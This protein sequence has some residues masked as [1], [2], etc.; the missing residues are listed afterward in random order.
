MANALFSYDDIAAGQR[1]ADVAGEKLPA[2][3][4]VLHAIKTGPKRRLPEAA[5]EAFSGGLLSN[6]YALFQDEFEWDSLPH[7]TSDYE[8][9]VRKGGAVVSID[10][11]SEDSQRF[12]DEVMKGTGFKQRTP[13][14]KGP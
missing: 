3:S 13:W 6:V 7:E 12:V 10:A 1:A 8:E 5:D 4:V 14:R 9:T 2:R 11:D